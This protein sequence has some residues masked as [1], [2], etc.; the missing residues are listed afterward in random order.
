M[1]QRNWIRFPKDISRVTLK[2]LGED[3]S[4]LREAEVIDESFGGLGIRVLD[5]E[6]LEIGQRIDVV[7]G[8]G[9]ITATIIYIDDE[10]NAS[11]RI[12]IRWIEPPEED[13]DEDE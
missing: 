2:P 1:R 6:G 7:Y 4:G 13:E 9:S 10:E 11:Y 5:A 12:G 8:Q 3:A